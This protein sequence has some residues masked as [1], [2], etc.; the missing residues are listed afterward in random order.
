[1]RTASS[2]QEALTLWSEWQPHILFIDLPGAAVDNQS[3]AQYMHQETQ[4]QN[5]AHLEEPIV[6]TKVIALVSQGQDP[7]ALKLATRDFDDVLYWPSQNTDLLEVLSRHLTLFHA[8][9][10]APVIT[11]QPPL[12]MPPPHQQRVA[13]ELLPASWRQRVYQAAITG[14]DD[15]LL[16]LIAQLPP[17]QLSLASLL[18]TLT[19][20][21]Q[22]D[23]IIALVSDAS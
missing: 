9:A 8:A 15:K 3:I 19:Q 21:F 13:I 16:S 6:T 2:R 10:D 1:M 18:N 23:Q 5:S 14:S 12:V 7:S 11:V 22:F 4:A 17:E 20:N